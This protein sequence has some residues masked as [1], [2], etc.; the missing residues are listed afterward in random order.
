[1]ADNEL[2]VQQGEQVMTPPMGNVWSSIHAESME[3]KLDLYDA[4]S[5]S[6]SLDDHVNEVISVQDVVIQPVEM[7][8][9]KT[10]EVVHRNRI[11]LVT[12]AGEAFGCVSSGV[13]TSLRNLFAIVGMP[14]WTP[15][16]DFKVVK[17]KGR[18]G[19][20]F[21]SLKRVKATE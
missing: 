21:T 2:M 17:K 19:Y 3:E 18:N 13:E 1:M 4:V 12:P 9:D 15:S 5:D 16:I 14:P 6:E 11:V 20:N 10:G 7:V 8:D